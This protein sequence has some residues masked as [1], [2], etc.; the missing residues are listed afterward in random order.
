[1]GVIVLVFVCDGVG[2]KVMVGVG[3]IVC[4]LVGVFDGGIVYSI[5]RIVTGEVIL[6]LMVSIAVILN[7][8]SPLLC[9]GIIT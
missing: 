2:V 4:V 9:F 3:V 5:S 8:K 1:V 7:L 6:K